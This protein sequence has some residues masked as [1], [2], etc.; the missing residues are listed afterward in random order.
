ME[1]DGVEV[2]LV[3]VK[4]MYTLFVYMARST[5]CKVCAQS[6]CWFSEPD[7]QLRRLQ[8]IPWER[9]GKCE[10]LDRLKIDT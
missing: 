8:C 4:C 1:T 3:I 6:K 10:G 2:L 7:A 5:S 9:L